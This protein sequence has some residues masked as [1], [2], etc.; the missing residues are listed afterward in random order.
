MAQAFNH[1]TWEAE[2]IDLYEFKS[3]LVYIAKVSQGYVVRTY[4]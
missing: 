3:N 4:L 2:T 1:T